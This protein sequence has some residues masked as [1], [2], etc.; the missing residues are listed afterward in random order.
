MYGIAASIAIVVLS[1][2]MFLT[3]NISKGHEEL[4]G[5]EVA[6]SHIRSLMVSHLYDIAS[7]DQHTVKPWF[8][9]KLNYSPSVKD[10]AAQGF[11]LLGGRLDY[12]DGKQVAAL[13]YRH[14]KHIIN[15]FEW[16]ASDNESMTRAVHQ[17]QG[18]NLISITHQ[19]MKYW[20]VSDLNAAELESLANLIN[21]NI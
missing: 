21:G 12:V 14:N 18:F 3:K 7:T 11:E 9:G 1:S 13:V 17:M 4:E 20:V 6:S 5:S 2:L 15:V 16:L 19:G 10:F 8:E